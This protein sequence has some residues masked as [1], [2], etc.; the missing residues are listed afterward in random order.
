V[1]PG[2]TFVSLIP[3]DSSSSVIE[4]SL[5]FDPPTLTSALRIATT[6]D[7]PALRA[8]AINKLEKT[9]LS[10]I[11]RIRIAREFNFTSWEAPAYVELCER[12]EAITED[13]ANVLGMSAF[14]HVAKIRE[15]EQR[16][17]GSLDAELQD[18]ETEEERGESGG[19]DLQAPTI[20]SRKQKRRKSKPTVPDGGSELLPEGVN[21]ADSVGEDKD[22]ECCDMLAMSYV[23]KQ[24]YHIVKAAAQNMKPCFIDVPGAR[25]NQIDVRLSNADSFELKIPGCECRVPAGRNY[26]KGYNSSR[27]GEGARCHCTISPCAAD[28]FEQLQVKQVAQAGNITKL[29]S[30]IEEIK[31]SLAPPP[32]NIV[33]PAFPGSPGS[34]KFASVHAE[35]HK[36]L[37]R[38]V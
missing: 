7:Y 32:D 15:K 10:A 6:Y 36:W 23:L 20:T 33:T 1:S 8:F 16:R 9:S 13:E 4:G 22:C 21:Q 26:V 35:V 2:L 3:I 5:D 25:I 29:E 11:E 12:D 38:R 14:V 17:K 27:A 18:D 24:C 19:L 28:A 30:A 31:L 37:S 34:I